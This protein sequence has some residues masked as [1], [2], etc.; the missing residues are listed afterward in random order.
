MKSQISLG[1]REILILVVLIVLALIVVVLTF[2]NRGWIISVLNELFG[3]NPQ[4]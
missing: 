3:S 2:L 4:V 1:L